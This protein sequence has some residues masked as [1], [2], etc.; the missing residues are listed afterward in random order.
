VLTLLVV[1]CVAVVLFL[2]ASVATSD[3]DLLVDVAPDGAG[4]R[5]PAGRVG[6]E[7]VDAL[8]FGL[9]VR[10]YRMDEVDRALARLAQEIA[11][12]DSR[13]A[14]LEQAIADAVGSAVDDVEAQLAAGAGERVDMEAQAAAELAAAREE[15]PVSPAALPVL[16]MPVT[17][18]LTSQPVTPP[19]SPAERPHVPEWPAGESTHPEPLVPPSLVA[20]ELPA[21]SEPEPP[22]LE[23]LET[24]PESAADEFDFPEIVP[25]APAP[26][27]LPEAAVADQDA[28]QDAALH[29]DRDTDGDRGLT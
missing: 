24:E 5:F 29:R 7:D 11:E 3:R 9:A 13:V 19:P 28:D 16:A 10:G 26:G 1:L 6:A 8:R 17:P 25:P 15:A 22:A 20:E 14:D 2:A 23:P 27:D 18:S 21:L 12:R 4:T